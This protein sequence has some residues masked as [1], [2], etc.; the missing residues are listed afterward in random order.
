MITLA[1]LN[2][3]VVGGTDCSKQF[4]KRGKRIGTLAQRRRR[5][6][7][8]RSKYLDRGFQ[9]P[10]SSIRLF[11]NRHSLLCEVLFLPKWTAFKPKPDGLLI[12]R[13]RTSRIEFSTTR[14]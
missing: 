10:N 6:P 13:N 3:A 12:A 5:V 8:L 14:T 4:R 2:S 1:L 11:L 7:M 9:C